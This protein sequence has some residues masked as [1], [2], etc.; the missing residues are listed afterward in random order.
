[1]RSLAR[2]HASCAPLCL[3]AHTH[4]GRASPG[5]RARCRPASIRGPPG[6]TGCRC[7]GGCFAQARHLSGQ[8]AGHGGGT[9]GR[10]HRLRRIIGCITSGHHPRL[11]GRQR[12]REHER[13]CWLHKCRRMHRRCC[14][15]PHQCRRMHGCRCRCSCAAAAGGRSAG[16]R[17]WRRGGVL[18]AHGLLGGAPARR[19]GGRAVGTAAGHSGSHSR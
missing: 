17:E 15:R 14:C 1:M 3:A 18:G 10:V 5:T 12:R 4:F 13:C 2:T 11:Q 16:R 9:P 6:A 8:W 19:S 7:A